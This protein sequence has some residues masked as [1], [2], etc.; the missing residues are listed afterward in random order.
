[1]SVWAVSMDLHCTRSPPVRSM[2]P[3]LT[4]GESDR[5]GV[6]QQRNG[7]GRR[8]G[9]RPVG[10]AGGSAGGLEQFDRV[11]CGVVEQDLLAADTG[12][13]V[14]AEPDARVTELVDY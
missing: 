12:D 10:S 2:R 13:D 4:G 11:A 14:V 3:G 1:M 8:S 7:C 6:D 5:H 9:R